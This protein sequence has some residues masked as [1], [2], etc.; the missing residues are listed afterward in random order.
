M[1]ITYIFPNEDS[2]YRVNITCGGTP[3]EI[4]NK[5]TDKYHLNITYNTTQKDKSK[6]HKC[7]DELAKYLLLDDQFNVIGK[8]CADHVNGNHKSIKDL[9]NCQYCGLNTQPITIGIGP[10]NFTFDLCSSI[11]T[12]STKFYEENHPQH[13]CT[14]CDKLSDFIDRDTG[15]YYCC[16]DSIGISNK[17]NLNQYRNCVVCEK[18]VSYGKKINHVCNTCKAPPKEKREKTNK[19]RKEKELSTVEKKRTSTIGPLKKKNKKM[20]HLPPDTYLSKEHEK[21]ELEDDVSINMSMESL[22]DICL[23]KE[24]VDNC[25]V[26]CNFLKIF[27]NDD[28][29]YNDSCDN[30]CDD[31]LD[32]FMGI[33]IHEV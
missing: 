17:S 10:N 8:S 25:N 18:F 23:P 12:E 31:D 21:L 11:V 30:V 15:N 27:S 16:L 24:Y 22:I 32:F 3:P 9:Q 2:T 19:K 20:N 14:N 4:P 29:C 5:G 26:S 33:D 13:K 7:K 28:S 6:C 1:N